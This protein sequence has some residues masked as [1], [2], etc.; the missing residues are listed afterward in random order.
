MEFR[1]EGRLAWFT[2]GTTDADSSSSSRFFTEKFD[3]LSAPVYQHSTS[4]QP[5]SLSGY[6]V[7]ETYPMDFTFPP[8]SS[9][10][11]SFHVSTNVG[12]EDSR[13]NPSEFFACGQC[14]N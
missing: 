9:F 11:I 3:T 2:A 14:I 1:K 4:H 6:I 12:D 5:P 7:H 8:S 10:S 13:M